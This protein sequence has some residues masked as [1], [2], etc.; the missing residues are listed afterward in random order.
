MNRGTW[1]R[2]LRLFCLALACF[3][4]HGASARPTKEEKVQRR[5]A[6][7]GV[8]SDVY[9]ASGCLGFMP[10]DFPCASQSIT[11]ALKHANLIEQ[12]IT[13]KDLGFARRLVKIQNLIET[14][15][16]SAAEKEVRNFLRSL[17]IEFTEASAPVVQPSKDLGESVYAQY[18][19]SCHGDGFGGEGKLSSKLKRLPPAFN[20]PDRFTTQF[21]FGIY[22]TMIHGI[23]DGEMTS[24]LDV[25]TV[26]ELWTAAFHVASLPYADAVTEL[27]ETL[28]PRFADHRDAFALSALAMS[29]DDELKKILLGRGFECGDCLREI[30]FLRTRAPW[31]ASTH[32]LSQE[33]KSPRDQSEYRALM[34]LL[35]MIVLVSGAFIYI[36]K[37]TGRVDDGS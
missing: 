15:D 8:F 32:R 3:V 36:L 13:E 4:A 7:W 35:V 23:D 1:C 29:T 17:M 37:R 18:C 5:S 11:D 26:D 34:L 28:E 12:S 19:Q 10:A 20:R 30:K 22:A 33:S 2:H 6:F 25:L 21:P 31:L 14:N 24:L 27:D 9:R 16:S